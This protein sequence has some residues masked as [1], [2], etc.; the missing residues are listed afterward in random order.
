M[1]HPARSTT[2][3]VLSLILVTLT[4][5]IVFAVVGHDAPAIRPGTF[6]TGNYVFPQNVTITNNAIVNGNVGIGT[7]SPTARIQGYVDANW[8]STN[9]AF[10]FQNNETQGAYGNTFLVKGGSNDVVPSTFQV[11]DFSGNVD[12]TVRG[13]GN[14]GIGTASPVVKMD[15]RDGNITSYKTSADTTGIQGDQIQIRTGSGILG[16]ISGISQGSG[17]PGGFGGALQLYSKVDNGATTERMRIDYLGNVGIGTTSPGSKL[18]V[19][20]TITVASIGSIAGVIAGSG[21]S[22]TN[23]VWGGSRTLSLG[24]SATYTYS[25]P[26]N[27]IIDVMDGAGNSRLVSLRYDATLQQLDTGVQSIIV[28]SNSPSAG[29]VG[30]YKAVNSWTFELRTG[31]SWTGNLAFNVR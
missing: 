13:D 7:V 3:L 20:G 8:D 9:F 25:F 22:S 18:D 12:F 1:A 16:A 2:K 29:Q 23:L 4:S 28:I 30:I 15:V 26:G 27:S 17:G 10:T 6:A 11:Q 5:T 24:S 31:S 21:G 19:N 14:V